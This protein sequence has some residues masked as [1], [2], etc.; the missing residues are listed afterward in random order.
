[1]NTTF[2]LKIGQQ[3]LQE[4]LQI[5]NNTEWVDF[6]GNSNNKSQLIDLLVKYLLEE[7]QIDKD[8]FVNNRLTTYLKA[9]SWKT[10]KVGDELYSQHK[11]ADHK[12]VSQTVFESERG[13]KTFVLADDS[14]ILI[15]LLWA[16][17]SFK[18]DVFL[19]QGK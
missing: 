7:Y 15:L 16:A 14:D 18:S 17:S 19:R 13:N 9:K 3:V 2:Q 11:E 10:F 1:M 6:L 12:I 8:I 4:S 5:I